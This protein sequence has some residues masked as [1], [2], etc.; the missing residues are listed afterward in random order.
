MC[1]TTRRRYSELS[2]SVPKCKRNDDWWFVH[3]VEAE[4]EEEAVPEMADKSFEELDFAGGVDDEE[5]GGLEFDLEDFLEDMDEDKSKASSSGDVDLD[6]DE[7][8][9]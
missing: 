9:K 2:T 1:A 7:E 5:E 3:T 4:A 8:E 6:L